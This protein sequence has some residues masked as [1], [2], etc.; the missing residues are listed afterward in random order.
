VATEITALG[1]R[2]NDETLLRGVAREVAVLAPA[3]N[4]RTANGNERIRYSTLPDGPKQTEIH[5]T[6]RA[7]EGNGQAT[8]AKTS[9]NSPGRLPK[10]EGID[11]KRAALEYP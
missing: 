4:Y 3:A 1:V 10:L 5:S 8:N 9:P 6:I 2:E 11:Y 7:N